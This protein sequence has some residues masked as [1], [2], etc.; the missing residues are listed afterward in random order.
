MGQ[1]FKL[2]FIFQI[3]NKLYTFPETGKVHKHVSLNHVIHVYDTKIVYSIIIYSLVTCHTRLFPQRENCTH[4]KVQ[5]DTTFCATNILT[6][7]DTYIFQTCITLL[8]YY[9]LLNFNH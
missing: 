3:N 5:I 1:Q 2:I 8:T 6:N 7:A 4:F 9:A